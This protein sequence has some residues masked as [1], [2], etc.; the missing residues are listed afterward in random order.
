M[1]REYYVASLKGEPTLKET[2]TIN[3]LKIRDKRTQAI[4]E[5]GGELENVIINPT[6]PDSVTQVGSDLPEDFKR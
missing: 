6:T 2:I 3:S 1:A 4:T 5:P